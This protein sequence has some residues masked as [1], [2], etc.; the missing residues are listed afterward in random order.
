MTRLMRCTACGWSGER[1]AV[2]L[3]IT[4]GVTCPRCGCWTLV[5]TVGPSLDV[6]E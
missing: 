5:S 2:P 3:V 1:A 4:S 6:Q